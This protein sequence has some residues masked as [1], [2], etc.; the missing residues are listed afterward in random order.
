MENVEVSLRELRLRPVLDPFR[1]IIWDL[2][3]AFRKPAED[4]GAETPEPWAS[5]AFLEACRAFLEAA[6]K[7]SAGKGDV[8]KGLAEI[9]DGCSAAAE[10]LRLLEAKQEPAEKASP[11]PART[12]QDTGAAFRSFFRKIDLGLPS[13]DALLFT[14][15]ILRGLGRVCAENGR[16]EPETAGKFA[17]E[18]GLDWEFEKRLSAAGVTW[19]QAE[20]LKL[21]LRILLERED[22][23][24]RSEKFEKLEVRARVALEELFT[25]QKVRQC[26]GVNI[27]NDELYYN[28]E[29]FLALLFW[30]GAA[31]LLRNRTE[32][33]T[34]EEILREDRG[35]WEEISRWY[36]AF[37][38]SD[39]LLDRLLDLLDPV[40]SA[41]KQDLEKG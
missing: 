4:G 13:E 34:K 12:E 32:A 10:I 6:K 3:P 16:E 22:W 28:R 33:H 31:A 8:E 20:R 25:D 18:F 11:K 15:A 21:L 23:F 24:A 37:E 1:R 17:D 30:L 9:R 38:R 27:Y 19:D 14:W 7:F 40:S 29:G 39:Y 35:V 26:A 36:D 5:A 2:L 41:R